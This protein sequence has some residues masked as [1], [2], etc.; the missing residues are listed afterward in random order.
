[1]REREKMMNKLEEIAQRILFLFRKG[2]KKKKRKNKA[3]GNKLNKSDYVITQLIKRKCY[4]NSG[5]IPLEIKQKPI[6]LLINHFI[7]K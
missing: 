5:K 1:M 6:I 3:S 2:K 4:E 7:M